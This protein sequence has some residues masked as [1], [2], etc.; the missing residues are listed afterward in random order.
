MSL[1]N[2]NG[3]PILDSRRSV[4]IHPSRKNSVIHNVNIDNLPSKA[5]LEEARNAE[6][7]EHEMGIWEAV[8]NYRKAVSW[9]LCFSSAIIMEG[10]DLTILGSFFISPTFVEHFGTLQD[11]GTKI[12]TAQWQSG[13]GVAMQSGQILGLFATGVLADRFGFKRVV[14]ASLL[15]VM[16]TVFLLFFAKNLVMLLVGEM[17]MGFPLG[18]FQTLSVT[19]ASEVC[20]TVIRP[21]LTTY[22]NLCWV[23]GQLLASGVTKGMFESRT[24]QWLY[25]I[26][27]ALQWVWPIPI[28]IGVILA[29]ESP[30]WLVR[31]GRIDEA[32]HSIARLA[33]AG[34]GCNP[35]ESVAM[36]IHTD[37]MEKEISAGTSYV[38]C[39]K[40]I[41]LRRTEIACGVWACQNL[42]GSGL[43]GASSY[44]YIA[45]GLDPSNAYTMALSQY[46]LG[47]IGVVISW[48]AMARI[49]RRTLYVYGLAIL[50][51][52][53]A[54]VGGI[55]MVPGARS[56]TPLA[57][58][59]WATGSMLLI[60][61]FIYDFTVGPVCY[62]L[63][64]E[65]PSTR[66][67]QKTVVLARNF[68][69]IIGLILGFI[70]PYMLNKKAWNLMG[71]SGWVWSGCAFL[72]TIWAFFRLP[73]PK[74]RT[75]AELDVLFERKISARKFHKTEVDMFN[76][77]NVES[78][79]IEF[80][81]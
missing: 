4:S 20:P 44:F 37:E 29:P 39:F 65:I 41:D 23:L 45:A 43:M 54:V 46:A 3:D 49:G 32:K 60:F 7:R 69:N 11:D 76:H 55:S 53:M 70:I 79:S 80:K 59:S 63:V 16:A 56:E 14:G 26:P 24:D 18:V 36:M 77:S 57:S 8:K 72:C 9:S 73:E 5:T 15:W 22:V 64:S 17:L 50:C 30:W 75:F 61:T 1:S 67:R 52:I 28:L 6:A 38:D 48:F 71:A 47:A 27:F 68:Y 12:I 74:D 34:S 25:K 42:C 35:D 78:I 40:G 10:Y 2:F 58:T 33:S 62:S 81:H 13:L 19:Y 51:L 66:L 21:Y 31:K